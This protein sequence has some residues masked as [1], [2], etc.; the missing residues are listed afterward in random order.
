MVLPRFAGKPLAVGAV[1]ALVVLSKF[2]KWILNRHEKPTLGVLLGILLG[3]AVGI[4]PLNA[5]S[6]P[7][8][9]L[10]GAPLTAARFACT[11]FLSRLNR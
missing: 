6:S 9:F 2:L 1:L 10:S 3:P 4:W 11:L 5:Q 7:F 8:D